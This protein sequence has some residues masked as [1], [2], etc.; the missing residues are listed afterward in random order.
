MNVNQTTKARFVLIGKLLLMLVFAISYQQWALYSSNQNTYFL[1]G[2]A[3]SGMGFLKLDWLA[4]TVDPFPVFS[5]LVKIT[6]QVLGENAFYFQYMVILA[7]FVYSI[8]G[9]ACYIC[10]IGNSRIKY[11]S[12][13]VL[14]TTLYSGLIFNLLLKIPGL[15][16]FTFIVNPE[17]LL[18]WGVAE[19]Y[20]LG[21]YF[22]PSTFG[23]F[24]ILSIYAF[25][26]DKPFV[27]IVCLILSA[28]FHSTYILSAAILTGTYMVVIFAKEKNLRKVLLVGIFAIILVIPI[29]TYVYLNFGPTTADISSQAQSILVDYRIP[30]HAILTNWFDNNTLYQI[31]LVILSIFLVRRT[32]LF[33]VLL[34][35]FL[36]ATFLTI[37]QVIT[38]NKSLALLFPWRIT[39]FLV[40]IASSIILASIVSVI[41][42]IFR[43][44][45]SKS[46]KPLQW[47][48]FVIII[49]LGYMGVRRT[50]T[51]LNTPRIGLTAS[52]RFITRTFQFNNLYLIPPDLETFR[53]ATKVPILIDY[54]SNP[55]KDTEVVEWFNRIKI[56]ND[57]YAA[58][59]E[60]ACSKLQ[61]I[62]NEYSITHVVIKNNSPI[63]K[64]ANCRNTAEL[65]RDANFVVYAVHG[66]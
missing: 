28:T 32:K 35:P 47:A 13:F 37:V 49:I 34:L 54:K 31:A 40:P 6:I 2:L 63:A 66:N 61:N 11:L 57:F 23:V 41:F 3:A 14:L 4:Q 17:G 30:H 50:I 64:I 5:A 27:A 10:G 25:L 56:T 29:L 15:A 44:P 8:L 43:K 62:S 22:Q 58:S 45:I 1:H 53:L 51:L 33:L 21:P 65:Y 18:T 7:I 38:G 55:F 9:I 46:T 19:Q 59:A 36:A 16:L 12:Y 52:A 26:R 39:V 20:I 60:T 42:Q 24:I 48:I